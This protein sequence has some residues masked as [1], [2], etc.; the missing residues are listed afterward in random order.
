MISDQNP[1][2]IFAWDYFTS[3]CK[4]GS[5]KLNQS[6]F[7]GSCQPR[8]FCCRCSKMYFHVEFERYTPEVEQKSPLK[9]YLLP[10]RKGSS[11][12]TL[13]FQGL[14][15]LNFGQSFV[16]WCPQRPPPAPDSRAAWQWNQLLEFS[17]SFND[18][19]Q[20]QVTR[21]GRFLEDHPT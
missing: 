9:T 13:H 18:R 5:R 21:C 1:G 14:L 11:E 20:P 16:F 3:R 17:V 19:S 12:P 15:L 10:K 8:G 2:C 6:G 7:S 4:K